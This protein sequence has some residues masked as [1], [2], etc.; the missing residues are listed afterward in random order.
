MNV[1]EAAMS[2]GFSGSDYFAVVFRRYTSV[3]PTQYARE[4]GKP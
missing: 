2:L 3:S 1:T 4:H